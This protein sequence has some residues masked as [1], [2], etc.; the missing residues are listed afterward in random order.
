MSRDIVRRRDRSWVHQG[1]GSIGPATTPG[2]T[3]GSTTFAAITPRVVASAIDRAAAAHD[4]VRDIDLPALRAA[5]DAGVALDPVERLEVRTR[6]R[7]IEEAMRHARAHDPASDPASTATLER[8]RRE[9]AAVRDEANALLGTQDLL[10][11]NRPTWDGDLAEIAPRLGLGAVTV[12][13]DATARAV[14][15][16][17]GARG[18]ALGSTVYLHPTRVRPGTSEG[19][20]VLAHELVHIAQARLVASAP[21]ADRGSAEREAALLAPRLAAGEAVGAPRVRIDLCQPAADTHAT[22][23]TPPKVGPDAIA[24]AELLIAG[25]ETQADVIVGSLKASRSVG[26][27][28]EIFEPL[29][30][31]IAGAVV[32]AE[33]M[34][35]SDPN[36][37][38]SRKQ[39]IPGLVERLWRLK[40]GVKRYEMKYRGNSIVARANGEAEPEPPSR[41]SAETSADTATVH[42]MHEALVSAIA[43]ASVGH[44]DRA[45]ELYIPVAERF[46]ELRYA[47]AS[48]AILRSLGSGRTHYELQLDEA[49]T[50]LLEL[51]SELFEAKQ[52]RLMVLA[53]ERFKIASEIL[54]VFN[55]EIAASDSKQVTDVVEASRHSLL[56]VWGP[57]LV[58]ASVYAAPEVIIWASANPNTALAAVETALA[59]AP[60]VIEA[61]GPLPWLED[62][63]TDPAKA[64]RFAFLMTN[65]WANLAM[66]RNADRATSTPRQ[67]DG[68]APESVR[69]RTANGASTG[70]ATRVPQRGDDGHEYQYNDM[71]PGPLTNNTMKVDKLNESPAVGFY[72]GQYDE[73]VLEQPMVVYRVAS[74]KEGNGDKATLGRWFTESPLQSGM[75]LQVDTAVRPVWPDKNGI[76]GNSRSL[77]EVSLTVHVPAGTTVYRGPVAPQGDAFVGGP[78]KIQLFIPNIRNQDGV[79]VLVVAPF[80]WHGHEQ[81]SPPEIEEP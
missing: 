24:E 49:S 10:A 14:T 40:D 77:P 55:G 78:D 73:I 59:L 45:I 32:L 25:A 29:F 50:G 28:D 9:R 46:H 65:A 57:A 66:G 52:P 69:E 34:L 8:V 47:D 80:T 44:V 70:D 61:G 2:R 18:V 41:V 38:E 76:I 15:E 75:Q 54:R 3:A 68:D 72:G 39:R 20:E 13:A 6:L 79:K 81:P 23:T 48:V 19:R 27:S 26:A 42:G 11:A 43:A 30:D 4:H 5:T 16:A 1:E 71:R 67:A 7:V 17:Q 58:Y 64:A 12:V 62:V 22:E 37:P 31:S 53:Y 33:A 51:R 21:S 56:V 36:L 63:A 60:D 35:F 74:A